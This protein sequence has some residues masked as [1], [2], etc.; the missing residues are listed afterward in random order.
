MVRHLHGGGRVG[1]A[2]R[3]LA[4]AVAQHGRAPRFVMGGD[5]GDLVAEAARHFGRVGGK[6]IAGG[7]IEPATLVLQGLR[8]VPVVQ[9][10]VRV[11]TLGGQGVEQSPIEVEAGLV[12]G[13]GTRG[14][15]ARP[16]HG[17]AVGVHA[18]AGD[19]LHVLRVAVIVVAGHVAIAA[20]DDLAIRMAEGIPDG[21]AAAV[22]GGGA[23]DLVGAGGHAPG[24]GGGKVGVNIVVMHGGHVSVSG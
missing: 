9:G 17:K 21:G 6:V 14:L 24:E 16:G 22:D 13:A 12:P 5:A 11:E 18:Q 4:R 19:Q 7:A 15:D 3:E 10:Q 20:V 1:H 8:Q 2:G 23:L